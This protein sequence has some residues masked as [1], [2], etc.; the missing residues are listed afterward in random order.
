MVPGACLLAMGYVALGARALNR[1][2]VTVRSDAIVIRHGPVPWPG[3]VYRR[4]ARCALLPRLRIIHTRGAEVQPVPHPVGTWQWS[5][6]DAVVGA[7][8]ERHRN[9]PCRGA[10]SHI[11]EHPVVND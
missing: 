9:G 6:C 10:D 7:G 1:T 5:P 4:S 3:S 2:E 11:P 8:Y